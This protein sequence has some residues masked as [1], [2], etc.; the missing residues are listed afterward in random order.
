MFYAALSLDLHR[1]ADPDKV[2]L[3][4]Y[5]KNVQARYAPFPYVEG[6]HFYD[7]FGHLNG[8]AA[9]YYTY[10]W[11]LVIAKDLLTPFKA[12]GL[13]DPE[14]D[15]KYRDEILAKGGTRD[16]AALVHDFLGRDYDFKA[17]EAWLNAE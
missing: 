6:S 2:D 16:A 8:Y 10:M 11:S 3:V 13:M 9:S 7:N 4:S 12:H 15:H 1:E 14:T 17:Y 5:M